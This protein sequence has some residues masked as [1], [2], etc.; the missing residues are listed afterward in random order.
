[1]PQHLEQLGF[2]LTCR[3]FERDVGKKDIGDTFAFL[4]SG[5]VKNRKK[6]RIYT[7]AHGVRELFPLA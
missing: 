2:P 4:I 3:P 6:R 5:E 7:P 1:M